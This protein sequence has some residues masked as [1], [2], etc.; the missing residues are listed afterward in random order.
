MTSTGF[1]DASFYFYL[2]FVYA[3]CSNFIFIILSVDRI[4]RMLIV[5]VNA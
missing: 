1:S 4:A 3:K 5:L 2:S